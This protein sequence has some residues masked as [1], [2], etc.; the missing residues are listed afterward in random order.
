M[1]V[2]GF[3]LLT[4]E[5]KAYKRT[6]SPGGKVL[7]WNGN[8]ITF[9]IHNNVPSGLNASEV[10]DAIRQSFAVWTQ[11]A[12][13]CLRFQ[14]N[15]MTSSPVLGYD[16]Q[17]PKA[18][19]N[20]VIFK[21]EGWAHSPQAVAITS[22][23]FNEDTG[24]IVAYDMEINAQHFTFSIDAQPRNGKNTMDIRNVVTH[25]VG[26]VIGLDHSRVRDSTMFTSGLP[27]ETKKR[28]LHSDDISGLCAIYPQD[29]CKF[30]TVTQPNTNT[31]NACGC[32]HTPG[33]SPATFLLALFVLLGF[34]LLQRK[35][36]S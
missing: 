23:I 31:N 36:I 12:C 27:G 1:L 15:G 3:S 13:T 34:A 6:V 28:D 30:T 2:L 8:N 14:D 5:A 25:E 7:F 29:G 35:R 9:Q 18:N 26:H 17:N 20:V 4:T 22:N 19:Q 10:Y 16:Q 32:H 11:E 33:D 24:E 21:F